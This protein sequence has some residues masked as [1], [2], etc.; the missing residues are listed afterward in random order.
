MKPYRAWNDAPS[1]VPTI[2]PWPGIVV[3]AGNLPSAVLSVMPALKL[4]PEMST[5]A[6]PLLASSMNSVISGSGA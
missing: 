3:P 1:P 4:Q 2:R 5:A 6:L